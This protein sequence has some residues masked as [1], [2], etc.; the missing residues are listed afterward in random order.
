MANWIEDYY[1][2]VDTHPDGDAV[3]K[4]YVDSAGSRCL[5][6]RD[7]KPMFPEDGDA[8]FDPQTYEIEVYDANRGQWLIVSSVA[9][10][11]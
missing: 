10:G 11:C 8:V 4:D 9:G 2:W 5:S 1:E 6:W 3:T 7:K